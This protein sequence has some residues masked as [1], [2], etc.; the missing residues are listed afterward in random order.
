[1]KVIGPADWKVTPWR[2]GQG[3]TAEIAVYPESG[4]LGAA[5]FDWRVSF[6]TMG[7]DADFSAF[8][9]FERILTVV[10]GDGLTLDAGPDEPCVEAAPLSPVAFPGER[11]VTGRLKAGSVKNLNLMTG[12]E[13]ARGQVRVLSLAGREQVVSGEASG[14]VLFS[15]GP[16]LLGPEALGPETLAVKDRI[17]GACYH[18]GAWEALLQCSAS[19]VAFELEVQ[20]KTQGKLVFLQISP[21]QG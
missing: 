21:V 8:P 3:E 7:E 18:L 20:G 17:S 5:A 11:K 10:A 9:G 4:D 14:L 2:S 16:E 6:A 13:R 15:L 12:R 1:M 19:E